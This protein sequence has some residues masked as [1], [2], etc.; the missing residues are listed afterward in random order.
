MARAWFHA[1][2][3]GSRGSARTCCGATAVAVGG[4]GAGGCVVTLVALGVVVSGAVGVAGGTGGCPGPLCAPAGNV[5]APIE[6]HGLAASQGFGN[7]PWEHP[8]R[9]I[10]LVCPAGTV[11]VATVGGVLHQRRGPPL[12]C[13]FPLGKRGGLGTFAEI[14]TGRFRILFGHLQAFAAPDGTV[15]SAAQPIGFEGSTGCSSGAHLHFEVDDGTVPVDPCPFLPSGYPS[16]HTD[17]GQRCWGSAP[18]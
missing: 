18:P 8:H 13:T 4:C 2:R 16:V 10:D 12:P 7:T 15:V 11:V 3:S 5:V 6:C 17:A 9:G 14:D 1:R